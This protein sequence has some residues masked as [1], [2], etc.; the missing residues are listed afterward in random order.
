MTYGCQTWIL[1]KQP[2]H[3]LQ[4]VQRAM[5]RKMLNIKLKDRVTTTGIRK[6]TQVIDV[7][8][9]IQSH[10]WRWAGHIARE[11]DNRWTKRCTERQPRSGR[12][13]RGRPEAGWIDDIRKAAG[14][15]WQRKAQDRRKWKTSAEGYTLQWVDKASKKME[16]ICRGLHPA[17]DGQSLQENRRHLQRATPCSGWTKPPRKW[18]ASA[19]GQSLQVTSNLG[20]YGLIRQKNKLSNTLKQRMRSFISRYSQPHDEGTSEGFCLVS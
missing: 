7:V 2:C 16:D 12:R 4:T 20:V 14:P 10:K 6:K 18:K 5:E 11:A 17:V 1:N 15:Q 19:E 9:Y 8:E 3:K 13:D